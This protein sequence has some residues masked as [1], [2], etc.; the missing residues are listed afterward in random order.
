MTCLDFFTPTYLEG[1][2]FF[3]DR[4]ERI[5]IA[6]GQSV[7]ESKAQYFHQQNSIE[8]VNHN[9]FQRFSRHA[10]TKYSFLYNRD[11]VQIASTIF[12]S[13][14]VDYPMSNSDH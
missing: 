3:D 13:A 2:D 4:I 1:L 14:L 5:R 7:P 12:P 6:K 10:A 11:R 9:L 8:Q